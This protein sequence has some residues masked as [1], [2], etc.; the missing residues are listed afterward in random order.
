MTW[1]N[2]YL[3]KES[4]YSGEV[5]TMHR[6]E[7]GVPLGDLQ[8]FS[9]SDRIFYDQVELEIPDKAR[10]KCYLLGEGN[11]YYAPKLIVDSKDLN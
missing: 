5:K 1:Y 10:I 7:K 4:Q 2:N 8:Q 9:R 11:I 6:T 3:K